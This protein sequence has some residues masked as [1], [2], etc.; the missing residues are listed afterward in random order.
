MSDAEKTQH[1]PVRQAVVLEENPYGPAL[2]LGAHAR[3]IEGMDEAASRTLIERLMAHAT[4][5]RFIYSH[6]WASHDLLIWDNRAVLHRATPFASTTERRH[7]VRTTVAGQGPTL[8]AA[9][10]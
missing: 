5:D 2:Y 6:R 9:A 8:R 10:A 7:M 1:P 4:E 3:S